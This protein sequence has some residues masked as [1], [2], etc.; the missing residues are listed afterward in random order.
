MGKITVGKARDRLFSIYLWVKVSGKNKLK[1]DMLN[2][3][4][5]EENVSVSNY[6]EGVDSL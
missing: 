2:Y 5:I 6:P 3:L 1:N 4:Y